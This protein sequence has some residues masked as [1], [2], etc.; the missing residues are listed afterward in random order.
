M[1][2]CTMHGQP[3]PALL[4]GEGVS[5]V[6]TCLG[7]RL[8]FLRPLQQFPRLAALVEAVQQLLGLQ[9]PLRTV[10]LT[11]LQLEDSAVAQSGRTG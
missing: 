8:Q 3:G 11:Q 7:P 4:L 10:E 2:W 9:R 6:E 1:C 5:E